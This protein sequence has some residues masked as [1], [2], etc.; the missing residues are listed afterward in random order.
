MSLSCVGGVNE[1][2]RATTHRVAKQAT[3]QHH[4]QA[5]ARAARRAPSHTPC[6]LT[7]L[8]RLQ[9]TPVRI[10]GSILLASREGELFRNCTGPL[11][12]QRPSAYRHHPQALARAARRALPRTPCE[13]T[14]LLGWQET[15]FRILGLIPRGVVAASMMRAACIADEP[16]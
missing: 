14:P 15:P 12:G 4:P 6:V 11:P 1:P 3:N 9:E 8:L 16:W 2:P 5:V 10:L 13:L 7:P